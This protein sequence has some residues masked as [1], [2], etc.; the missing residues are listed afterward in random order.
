M[1]L[2]VKLLSRLSFDAITVSR[3]AAGGVGICLGLLGATSASSQSLLQQKQ[4]QDSRQ[5]AQ[6]K[7]QADQYVSSEIWTCDVSAEGYPFKFIHLAFTRD[8]AKVLPHPYRVKLSDMDMSNFL[9]AEW[10]GKYTTNKEGVRSWRLDD[11]T[12][13]GSLHEFHPDKKTYAGKFGYQGGNGKQIY[14][15]RN[16]VLVKQPG[17]NAR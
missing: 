13:E 10:V 3:A 9:Y 14:V 8:R 4:E 5:S 16:C 15:A 7:A 6:E 12:K 17:S 1:T 11:L 2:L